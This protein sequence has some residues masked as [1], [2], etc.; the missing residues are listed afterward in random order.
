MILV[1]HSV[2]VPL[3]LM[4]FTNH[5][6]NEAKFAAASELPVSQLFGCK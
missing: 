6:A 3:I 4:V 5:V 1:A 2:H